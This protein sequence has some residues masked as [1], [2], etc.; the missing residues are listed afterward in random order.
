M[1]YTLSVVDIEKLQNNMPGLMQMALDQ[2]EAVMSD[3]NAGADEKLKAFRELKTI[4]KETT[5]SVTGTHVETVSDF[6]EWNPAYLNVVVGKVM[7]ALEFADWQVKDVELAKRIVTAWCGQQAKMA[8]QMIETG[9]R[10]EDL[11]LR[12]DGFRWDWADEGRPAD[13]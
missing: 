6:V 5:G 11:E 8:G 1:R 12:D 7:E 13:D 2:V 10:K 4:V 9:Q 3:P